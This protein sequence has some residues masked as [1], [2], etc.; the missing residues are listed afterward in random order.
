MAP[1][2]LPVDASRCWHVR[3]FWPNTHERLLAGVTKI[4]K[5]KSWSILPWDIEVSD[6]QTCC[7]SEQ[8]NPGGTLL[9]GLSQLNQELQAVLTGQDTLHQDVSTPGCVRTSWEAYMYGLLAPNLNK[10]SIELNFACRLQWSQIL[11]GFLIDSDVSRRDRVWGSKLWFWVSFE[12]EIK[13]TIY[14]GKLTFWQTC[15]CLGELQG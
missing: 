11:G 1:K 14:L 8:G 10:D 3:Q 12:A 2:S 13:F 7:D 6:V 5:M 4:K 9:W 15:Y